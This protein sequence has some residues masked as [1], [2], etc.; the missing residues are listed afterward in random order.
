MIVYR[1][2]FHPLAK[3]PGP[4]LHAASRLP[5]LYLQNIKGIWVHEAADFHARYGPVVRVGPDSLSVDG[6]VAWKEIF[7]QRPAG[8]AE[9]LKHPLRYDEYYTESILHTSTAAHRRLRR[10]FAPAFTERAI[11]AQEPI[12]QKYVSLMLTQLAQR[13]DQPVDLN[14]WICYTMFDISGELTFGESFGGVETGELHDWIRLIFDSVRLG[15]MARFFREYRWLKILLPLLVTKATIAKKEAH[16]KLVHDCVERRLA[17]GADA[18]QDFM[19]H[20]IPYL[21]KGELTRAQLEVNAGLFIIAGSETSAVASSTLLYYL[22]Q[23]PEAYAELTREIREAFQSEDDITVVSTAR[24]TYLNMCLR[25]AMRLHAPA[26][27]V[28]ERESPGEFVGGYWAPKGVSSLLS[29]LL[30]LMN[31]FSPK[32]SE[33][34]FAFLPFYLFTPFSPFLFFPP[35][36]FSN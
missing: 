29:T 4:K 15:S 10:I 14:Q 23:E 11:R 34:P 21:E 26:P 35:F 7:S 3:V 5:M 9:F 31:I 30:P 19:T 6:S 20:F 33:L 16:E 27:E 13:V 28:A 24:L 32:I 8:K 17:A 2:Y 1:V 18:K 36:Q 22:C 25:E 12:L